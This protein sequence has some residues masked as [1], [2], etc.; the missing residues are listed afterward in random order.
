M[1]TQATLTCEKV[2]AMPEAEKIFDMLQNLDNNPLDSWRLVYKLRDALR[3]K[4][5]DAATCT[6][7]AR[8]RLNIEV[9]LRAV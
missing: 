4:D 3:D 7:L 5:L 6:K 8:V 9:I 1:G 2:S